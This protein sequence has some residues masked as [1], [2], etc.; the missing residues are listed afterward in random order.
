MY[1]RYF[2]SFFYFYKAMDNCDEDYFVS[3]VYGY[4][5]KILG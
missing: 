4:R 5:N 1:K 2:L 3:S